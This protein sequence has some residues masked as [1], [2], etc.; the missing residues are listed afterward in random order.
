MNT[1][2]CTIER[3]LLVNYRIDPEL[4]LPLLPQPFTPQLV[5]GWAVGGV[6]FLRLNDLRP[7]GLPRALGF[8]TENVA[9][10]F[11]VEWDVG[12]GCQTGVFVP[13]RHTD[14]RITAIVGG[15]IFPG[16]HRIAQFQVSD[17]N[18]ALKIDVLSGDHSVSLSVSA[19]ESDSLDSRI[20]GSVAD[21]MGFFRNGCL[22]YSPDSRSRLL[23]GVRLVSDRWAANPVRVGTM[24]SSLFDD[25]ELFPPGTCI[26]DSALVMRN[27]P[28]LWRT[29]PPLMVKS[30]VGV[31]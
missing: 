8:S 30:P 10:R 18:G 13:Q 23:D 25:P 27:L 19:T 15:R 4:V 31:R 16:D 21:A 3:R 28:V 7:A 20:F 14:S 1:V 2:A 29:E 26:L 22:G 9:H 11:G 17:N 6:C 5:D 24:R 12:D